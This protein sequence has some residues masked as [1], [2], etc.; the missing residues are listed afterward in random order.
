MRWDPSNSTLSE[1]YYIPRG[2][3]L[4]SFVQCPVALPDYFV[5]ADPAI[6]I[7]VYTEQQERYILE[8]FLS[9]VQLKSSKQQIIFAVLSCTF[10]G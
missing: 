2:P 7:H 4:I 8:A 1:K 3:L 5:Y 9:N 6:N 10:D